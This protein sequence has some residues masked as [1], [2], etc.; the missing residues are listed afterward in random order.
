M[1]GHDEIRHLPFAAI[2]PDRNRVVWALPAAQ[3]G[4]K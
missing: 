4:I 1:G 3:M 2:R